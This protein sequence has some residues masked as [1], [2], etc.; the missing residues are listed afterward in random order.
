MLKK[1]KNLPANA[2]NA[3]KGVDSEDARSSLL[4]LERSLGA[5]WRES[6]AL[7]IGAP[8]L[9]LGETEALQASIENLTDCYTSVRRLQNSPMPVTAQG[10]VE[11]I[12]AHIAA[13]KQLIADR[14]LVGDKAKNVAFKTLNMLFAGE[15]DVKHRFSL[16]GNGIPASAPAPTMH[17]EASTAIKPNTPTM[18][19]SSAMMFQL[20]QDLFPAERM[21]VGAGRR[22]G[23]VISIE[24]L[25][26]VTGQASAGAVKADPDRLAQALI[27]MSQTGTYFALWIHSHPG[28]GPDATM[29]SPVDVHQHADWLKNYS[30]DLVSAIMVADRFIRFW[31]TAVETGNIAVVISGDGVAKVSTRIYKVEV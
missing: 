4:N 31:G 20:R 16:S 17:T 26:D 23:R 5:E 3:F 15:Q 22:N 2:R 30:P 12:A 6:L 24:A 21:I 13:T 18:Q 27:A 7:V 1:I 29:P 11:A 10:A 9:D 25:F 8:R 28:L 14:D 19:L